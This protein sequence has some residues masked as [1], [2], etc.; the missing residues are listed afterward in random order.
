MS[1]LTGLVAVGDYS[2]AATGAAAVDVLLAL[3]PNPDSTSTSG[4]QAGGG[5]LD[6]MSAGAAAGIRIELLAMRA[7][8]AAYA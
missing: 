1:A 3:I 4:A 5:F 2:G 6:E 7:K 8:I